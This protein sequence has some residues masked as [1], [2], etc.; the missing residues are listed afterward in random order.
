MRKIPTLL[1]L[2]EAIKPYTIYC[3]MD[4]VLCDFDQGYKDL[5]GE[6]TDEANAE[7][8]SYFWKLFR[9][10]VRENEKDF[11]ANL[12]WQSGGQELWNYIKSSNP[13]ILSAPS[14]DFSLPQ[15]QQLNPE[16]NQA[17]QG[18]KNGLLKILMDV[19]EEIFVPASQKS[20]FATSKHI[21]ID[22]MQ[23]N[24]DAWR[25]A[26]GRAILHTSTAKQLNNY[27]N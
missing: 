15:D 8:K 13:N 1:D 4:G 20:S 3:D 21:L 6:S 26:G 9:E 10:S 12:P 17:I 27:K 16:F 24:I 18:K 25:A 14:V 22:D 2:Y 19:N 11:W 23:K 5:T 7:G